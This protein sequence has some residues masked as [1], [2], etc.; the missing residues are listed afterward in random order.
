MFKYFYLVKLNAL[1]T[2][3]SST[4]IQLT[5]WLWKANLANSYNAANSY[6]LSEWPKASLYIFLNNWV[7]K[8]KVLNN[9]HLLYSVFK[10]LKKTSMY[11]LMLLSL[12]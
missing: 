11:A 7:S 2:H 5:Q 6:I 10:L 9:P 3:F 4:T 1:A 12:I 8:N